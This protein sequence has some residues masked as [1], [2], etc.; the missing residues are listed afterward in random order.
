MTG[1]CAYSYECERWRS[2]CGSCPYLR[3]YP[4]LRRDTTALLWRVKKAIYDR[5]ELTLVAPSKW[6]AKLAKQSPLLGRFPIHVIPNGLDITVFRPIPKIAARRMFGVHPQSHVLFF[7]ASVSDRRKGATFLA[8]ALVRLSLDGWKDLMLLVAGPDGGR[9]NI[10]APFPVVRLGEIRDDQKLAAAYAAAD[11]FVLPTLADTLPN[12]VV[13][14][15]ACGTPTVSFDVGGVSDAV[16]HMETGY[17]A[18]S[19]DSADL[20]RGIARLLNDKNLRLQMGHRCREIAEREYSLEQQA[21]AFEE[22]YRTVVGQRHPGSAT[23]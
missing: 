19:R 20:A 8:E 23:L 2:G 14:S 6:V 13:E 7:S 10:D 16:M 3:D 5:S 17:L 15:M 21:Q 1:H 9:W 18:V 22:L 12:G 11:L 4:G